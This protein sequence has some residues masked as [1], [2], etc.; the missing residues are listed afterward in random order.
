M[1]SPIVHVVGARPNFM[2]AAPVIKACEERGLSQQLIHTGQHYDSSLSSVFFDQL[3]LP[4]PDIYLGV[5]SSPHGRQTG[6]AMSALEEEFEASPPEACI[7]YGDVNST[8]AAALVCSKMQIPVAHVEAGLRSF[9]RTMPEEINRILTDAV[10]DLLLIS[11]P[12]AYW[13][14]G[15]EGIDLR[16]VEFIGNTMIDTLVLGLEYIDANPVTLPIAPP[17]AYVLITLHRPANVDDPDRLRAII[18][19]IAKTAEHTPCI[20]PVHPR[21]R[22]AIDRVGGSSIPGLSILEPQGY[23]EFLTLQRNAATVITD[24]GGIQEETTVLGI[25]CVT[26]RPNTERPITLSMGTN[27]LAEPSGLADATSLALERATAVS[28][29]T[30]PLWDGQSG[31]RAAE[32]ISRWVR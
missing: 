5:G 12:E 25:P 13:N 16:R 11:S 26:V 7:V 1:N 6:K 23:L 21:G 30:P 27:V 9:D 4:K 29:T 15:N 31:M 19:A 14:L 24:S 28:P 10:S 17:E 32:A 20:F 18:E 8:L 2:K 3:S 22:D